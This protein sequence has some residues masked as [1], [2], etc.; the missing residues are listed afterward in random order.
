MTRP[1]NTRIDEARFYLLKDITD[2]HAGKNVM[3]VHAVRVDDLVVCFDTKR[4]RD[5]QYKYGVYRLCRYP[6]LV[7]HIA[8]GHADDL[9][10]VFD[11]AR[12]LNDGADA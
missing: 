4:N 9:G 12:A 10:I 5:G 6:D 1:T 7:T 8:A 11:I 3:T 2:G